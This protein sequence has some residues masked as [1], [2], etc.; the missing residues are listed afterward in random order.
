MIYDNPWNFIGTLLMFEGIQ[1]DCVDNVSREIEPPTIPGFITLYSSKFQINVL[2]QLRVFDR[3]QGEPG[4]IHAPQIRC[5]FMVFRALRWQK[6]RVILTKSLVRIDFSFS[7]LPCC[8]VSTLLNH[9]LCCLWASFGMF[10]HGSRTVKRRAEEPFDTDGLPMRHVSEDNLPSQLR[11]TC[12]ETSPHTSRFCLMWETDKN[13]H[14][15]VYAWAY[16]PGYLNDS[17]GPGSLLFRP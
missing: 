2:N 17:R 9:C 6:V 10:N 8:N 7:L 5:Y 3:C 12:L 4:S 1:N 15:C 13:G 14:L 11:H 16:T